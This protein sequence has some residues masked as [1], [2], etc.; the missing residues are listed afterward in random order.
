[1]GSWKSKFPSKWL[2]AADLDGPRL[3]TIKE[4]QDEDVAGD[5]LEKPVAYFHGETKGLGLN[6]TNCRTL[7]KILGTDDV[8]RWIGKTV[9]IFKTET[10]YK[11]ERVDC[12]RIRAPKPGAKLPEPPPQEPDELEG[13]GWQ[14]EDDDVPF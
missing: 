4:V 10:D 13:G 9:V 1:M 14:A 7:E 12:I 3:V 5:G 6:V 11:G 8:D 2:K